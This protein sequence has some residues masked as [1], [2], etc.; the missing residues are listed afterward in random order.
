M[1]TTPAPDEIEV[2]IF[3][4]GFGECI[5]VHL[6][7]GDWIVVDSFRTPQNKNPV[8][9][10]Y[11]NS[12]AVDHKKAV[13]AIVATHWH[14]DHISGLHQLVVNCESALFICSA[15]IGRYE[16][17][18][19]LC[20]DEDLKEGRHG[21]Q[22]L[23][24][25][26]SVLSE[27]KASVGL[28]SENKNLIIKPHYKICSLSPSDTAI[29]LAQKEIATLLPKE[30]Q[31]RKGIPVFN[32]NHSSVVLSVCIGEKYILLG[33]DL[34]EAADKNIGWSR[35]L[36]TP[37][38]FEQK[39]NA[40]KIPHH[41]SVTGH[42]DDVW[43]EMLM[44]NPVSFLSAF[45]RGSRA[46]PKGGDIQRILQFTNKAW[47]TTNPFV[48]K[49]SFKRDA[50]VEKTIKET[51]R[52]IHAFSDAGHIRLRSKLNEKDWRV[53]LFGAAQPLENCLPTK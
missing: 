13:K 29:I 14:D 42:N 11:L 49:K 40:F 46:L 5:L 24:K 10:E 3:G 53:D 15:A 6:G 19:F 27:R 9:I 28:A 45:I 25:I 39:S 26:L 1:D 22:E 8:A 18:E 51:A 34:E 43:K 23:R 41:G 31:I 33:A 50:S 16:F 48:R 32:P 37:G 36:C 4:K 38:R 12:L 7:C 44:P 47:I 21:I 20:I 35:I 52:M 30:M 2:S 17:L